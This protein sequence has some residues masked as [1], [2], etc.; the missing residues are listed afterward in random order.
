MG[1]LIGGAGLWVKMMKTR[2]WAVLWPVES[3]CCITGVSKRGDDV[4][5]QNDPNNEENCGMVT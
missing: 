4:V 2:V 5:S 3:V 1:R